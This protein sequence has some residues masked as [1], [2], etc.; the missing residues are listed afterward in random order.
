MSK[1]QATLTCS[2]DTYERCTLKVELVFSG[3]D[4]RRILQ[5]GQ[6]S[7]YHS[8]KLMSYDHRYKE[9][10][11]SLKCKVKD[12]EVVQEFAFRPRP[13]GEN[14]MSFVFL[15]LVIGLQVLLSRQDQT[16]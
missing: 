1:D 13:S 6:Y 3:D 12:G 8:L 4:E 2:V 14:K 7:C 16:Q 9:R 5:T 15:F 11:E 10:Y